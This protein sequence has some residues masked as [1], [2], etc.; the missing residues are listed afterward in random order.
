MCIR[1]SIKGTG[2]ADLL[3]VFDNTTEV[4]TIKDGGNLGVGNNNPLYKLSVLTSGTTDT[5]L[6]LATSGGASDNGLATNSIRFTGG[7][8]TRWANAKYEAFNHIFHGNGG[9]KLRIDSSGR[10]GINDGSRLASDANEG[11]QLRVTGV[12]ITRNQ[13]YSPGGNY[14][15]SFGYTDNTYAKSWIAVDSSYAKSSAVSAGIFLSAFH[16]DAGGSGCGFTIKNLRNGNPLVISS[17]VTA[18]SVNN[19]AVETERLRI[20]SDGSTYRGG[21]VITESDMNWAHDTYQRPHIFSGQV[22][23]NP[24]DGAIVLASPE[25]NPS[26]T[27]IGALVYGCK[28][29][30]TS[31]VSNS[32][33]KAAIECYSNTNVSDAWKT[34][35]HL[36]FHVRPDNANLTEALR[37]NSTGSVT[38]SL[39]P[40]FYARRSTAGDGRGAGAQEWTIS[41]V[42]SYNTGSHF[43]TSNGRFTA[44]V[45][46]K[47][48]FIAQPGYKQTSNNYQFYF[49]INNSNANEPVRYIDGGGSL[50]S[51]SAGTGSAILNL[52]VNDYVDIYIGNT[53]HANT[54][55]NFFTGYLLG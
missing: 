22:G 10:L 13:Y 28:T 48:I 19:P 36:R 32:G 8:N 34:G 53:H 43:N 50:P 42:A 41:G 38:K 20:A 2:T 39:Q 15:G 7:N 46:G 49:R 47:Y 54:T 23:G 44:P 37:I 18:A 29:S 51:H 24:S 12:P 55:Y 40:G 25:T 31:G 11:A 33:L 26:N 1:D 3:N 6:H 45:A 16:Q 21:T 35:G 5:L 17:V 52:A 9:E 27:R 14:Y 30:S 4:F